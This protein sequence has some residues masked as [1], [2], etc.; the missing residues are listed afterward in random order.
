MS[1]KK[2]PDALLEAVLA[3]ATPQRFRNWIAV[4]LTVGVLLM[5]F[6]VGMYWAR[7]G[8]QVIS[9]KPEDWAA[10]GSYVGGTAGPLLA[11]L[12]V[13]L[14]VI[15]LALQLR[16]FEDSRE[17][18]TA[19]RRELERAH[20]MQLTMVKTMNQ[21][22]HYATVSAR[23]AALNSAVTVVQ[24]QIGQVGPLGQQFGSEDYLRL[25]KQHE[26]FIQEILELTDELS[27][28]KREFAQGVEPSA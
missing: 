12:T 16:Q 15:T 9:G 6:V 10:F 7:F 11:F 28:T 23:V 26:V 22:A 19:S 17:Q 20:D 27:K 13:F 1:T 2:N 24:H 14:L 21:Q 5:I 3:R 8:G 4:C 18:L 25:S